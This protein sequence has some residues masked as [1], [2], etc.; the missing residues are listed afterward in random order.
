MNVGV[1]DMHIDLSDEMGLTARRVATF[2]S[3]AVFARLS[4][5]NLPR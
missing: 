1:I 4:D 5:A 2:D 3:K